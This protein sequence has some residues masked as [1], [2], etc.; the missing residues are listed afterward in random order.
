MN[1]KAVKHN[2]SGRESVSGKSAIHPNQMGDHLQMDGEIL[3]KCYVSW[4]YNDLE[5]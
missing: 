1:G 2:H 5:M 3:A 4:K